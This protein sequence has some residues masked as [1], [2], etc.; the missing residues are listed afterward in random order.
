MSQFVARVGHIGVDFIEENLVSGGPCGGTSF[1]SSSL[2]C[3]CWPRR[4]GAL[5]GLSAS[6]CV[7]SG[8]GGARG[9]DRTGTTEVWGV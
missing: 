9:R 3:G 5:V 1:P 8:E 6:T 7:F 2:D 4:L